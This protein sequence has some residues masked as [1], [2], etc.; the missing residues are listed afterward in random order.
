M[1]KLIIAVFV[2]ML[3]VTLTGCSNF[4]KIQIM[5]SWT[6]GTDIIVGDGYY[7]QDFKREEQG[8]K[9]TI[10]INFIKK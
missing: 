1:K 8:D 7:F 5:Q 10:S 9:L 6:S 2:F 3:V 4:T